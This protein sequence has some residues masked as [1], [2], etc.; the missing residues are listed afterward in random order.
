MKNAKRALA[1]LLCLVMVLSFVPAHG[2]AAGSATNVSMTVDKTQVEVG[3]NVVVT[4]RHSEMT[5]SS[6]TC[7]V[8]FDPAKMECVSIVGPDPE[9]PSDF[10]LTKD[11][12]R[13]PW[14]NATGVS[15]VAE[16]NG[17]GNV[18]FAVANTVDATYLEDVIFT[19]TFKAKVDGE[20]TVKLYEDSAGAEGYKNDN[21]ETK[22]VTIGSS[23]PTEPEKPTEPACDHEGKTYTYTSN[24]NGTGT[25]KV[26]CE[27]GETVAES[28]TCSDT[29]TNTVDATC[30]VDGKTTVTCNDCGQ[31]VSETSISAGHKYGTLIPA[32]EAVHTQTELKPAVAAH[33]I[34][35]E[36][37]SYFTEGKVETTLD[38]LTGE[39]PEHTVDPTKTTETTTE[40]TCTEEGSVVTETF[41][42]CGKHLRTSTETLP[43]TD[44]SWGT[45]SYSWTADYTACTATR[46]CKNNANHEE[47]SEA[48]VT[49]EVT[50]TGTCQTAEVVTYTAT[51]EED[52]AKTQTN[53]VTGKKDMTNHT[54]T[55]KTSYED[56]KDGKTHT[57]TVT[58]PCCGT[59][60]STTEN[61]NYVDGECVCEGV[62]SYTLTIQ[63]QTTDT[64]V[65]LTVPYGAYLLE[66]LGEA[67]EDG[68]IPAIGEWVSIENDNQKGE[69]CIQG[70]GYWHESNNY[71]ILIGDGNTMPAHDFEIESL[72]IYKGWLSDNNGT[73]FLDRDTEPFNLSGWQYIEED[74]DG[75]N[76]GA[77]YYF[78][79]TTYYRAEGLTRVPYPTTAINGIT[80]APDAEAMEYDSDFID[81]TEAWFMFENDGK[82]DY[83]DN[84]YISRGDNVGK[85]VDGMLAWHPGLIEVREGVYAYFIGDVENG[86]NIGAN[87]DTYITKNNGNEQF[88]EGDIYNFENG[89]LSG[90]DGIVDGKYYE[91]SRLMIGNG[92]TKVGE[93]FIYVRSNGYLVVSAEYYVPANDLGVVPGTYD[94]DENGYLVNPLPTTKNGI[95]E[96]DGVLY[97]YQNGVKAYGAG[98]IKVGDD[99]IYVRSNGALAIGRYWITTTNDLMAAG[100]YDFDENGFMK[101]IKEGIVAEN[102]SLYYYVN[103]EIAYNAGVI[104][105]D[106]NYYYVRSNGEVVNNRNYW[107]TNVGESGVVAKQ[108]TF[109]EN[110]VMQNPEFTADLKNGI[111]DGYY[112][113]N[114]KIVYG[115]G[116][117]EY[118]NGVIYVR[119]NGMVATGKYWV[120]NT[121]GLMEAGYYTFGEDGM[122]II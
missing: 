78:D 112:Y 63:V 83:E 54:G 14:V 56:K 70:Y 49:S 79:E 38:E 74:Y 27:C 9:Y 93:N 94:F 61:H 26:T 85:L 86:G 36:C 73:R 3:D 114:G 8:T 68:K 110:G 23:T 20:T 16:A 13:N 46:V 42:S 96:E 4:V 106:G 18:G 44:H 5:V 58:Y 15:T 101:A 88:A 37:G 82:F 41:C 55:A 122:M 1:L 57:V 98:L 62:Q 2:F 121:N 76:G 28:E 53:P 12:G 40:P 87:G 50:T 30:T 99:Y 75:V 108:Y 6:F 92:L 34:C 103:N 33:Y 17:N 116:L 89:E 25:H 80:Y 60:T 24:G 102:G 11:S 10:Y 71:V 21:I 109:D 59:S 47:T 105:V 48:E 113:E 43:A 31:T 29:T 19:V 91:N 84:G 117:I 115:A 104:K 120:T 90:A 52:W 65:K 51:F 107:I 32:Q 66:A 97:F 95:V 100:Y 111:V 72:D 35:S 64:T 22:T 118:N 7:G 81:A 39:T 67:A 69:F 77:W 119:S 45:T